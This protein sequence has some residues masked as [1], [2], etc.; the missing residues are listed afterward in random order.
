MGTGSRSRHQPSVVRPGAWHYQPVPEPADEARPA[1]VVPIDGDYGELR[2]P[3]PGE[4]LNVLGQH[5]QD[6]FTVSGVLPPI[7]E[8]RSYAFHGTVSVID[9]GSGTPDSSRW[10]VNADRVQCACG[11][12]E[13]VCLDSER[14][15]DAVLEQLRAHHAD[16]ANL[17]RT[18]RGVDADLAD[19]HQAS[20]RA[21]NQAEA[22]W[23]QPPEVSYTEDF[24]AFRADYHEAMARQARGDDPVPYMTDDATGRLGA[25]D[26]GRGFGVELEFD[27]EPTVAN[28]AAAM[29]AITRDLRAAGL[30]RQRSQGRYHAAAGRGYSD[31]PTA[32]SLESDA[33]VAGELVSPILYDEPQT[34]RNLAAACEIIRRHGGRASTHTG[35]HVHVSLHDYDHTVDNHNRLLGLV[36]GYQDTIYRLAANP[37]RRSHRG[38]AWCVPNRNSGN[39]YRT[40][41]H[42]RGD[43]GGHAIGVNLQAVWGRL[44]DHVEF[45]MW[46]G[47]IDPGTI[48]AQIK[49]SLGLAHAAF[50]TAGSGAS[51]PPP[52][53][54]GTHHRTN[55]GRQRLTGDAWREA[56]GSFRNLVDTLFT[57]AADK[58]QATALFASTRWPTGSG[59]LAA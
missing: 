23:P 27:F 46:D 11:H 9:R 3:P 39:G 17:R 41:E 18:T 53:P 44:S 48:Q 6:T 49:L 10:D 26:G 42:A 22:T 20:Q 24:D 13:N 57:R 2:M 19:E 4:V 51:L 37:Q 59:R 34:W 45:R 33:T 50:R 56:T 36:S 5:G 1:V 15:A 29:A 25:R 21:Q 12:E 14:V 16:T 38:L 47:S 30:T 31:D 55:P 58:A 40:I 52:E 43:N 32:W 8:G 35:G 7:G 28:R 54:V